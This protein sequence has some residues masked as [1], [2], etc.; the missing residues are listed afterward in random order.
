ML[1]S[2]RGLIKRL[3]VFNNEDILQRME[4]RP[5]ELFSILSTFHADDLSRQKLGAN[6]DVLSKF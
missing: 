1:Q 5:T 3:Q 6:M 4:I 2:L